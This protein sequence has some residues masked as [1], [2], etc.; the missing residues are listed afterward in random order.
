M[1]HLEIQRMAFVDEVRLIYEM[2]LRVEA[3]QFWGLN[4]IALHPDAET[5]SHLRCSRL[6]SL[7]SVTEP[8]WFSPN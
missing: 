2:V 8:I 1:V 5:A 3:N 7:F 6:I 4:L